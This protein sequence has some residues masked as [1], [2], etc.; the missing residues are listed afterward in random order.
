MKDF[1]VRSEKENLMLDTG[2]WVKDEKAVARDWVLG[3]GL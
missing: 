1:I 2:Y 3:A